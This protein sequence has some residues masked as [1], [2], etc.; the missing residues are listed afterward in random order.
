MPEKNFF[1]SGENKRG[2]FMV[3]G[4]NGCEDV[5]SVGWWMA[6]SASRRRGRKARK[7]TLVGCWSGSTGEPRQAVGV[8]EVE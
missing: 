1:L 3:D 2:L 6:E 5:V 8:A 7:H 4:A